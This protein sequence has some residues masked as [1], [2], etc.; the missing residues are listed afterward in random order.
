MQSLVDEA[1]DQFVGIVSK[2]RKMD[3]K[4][5]RELADGRIYSALQAKEN[6]LIDE[7]SQY[8]E[9][10]AAFLEAEEWSESVMFHAPVT[11][12][13]SLLSLFYGM[14]SELKPKT[15]SEVATEILESQKNGVLMYYAE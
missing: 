15:D 7:V 6:D 9:C 8:A 11:E 2:G 10:K 12:N 5:V 1:Y 13:D 14:L 4:Q 3:E